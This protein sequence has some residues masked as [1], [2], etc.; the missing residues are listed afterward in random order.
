MRFFPGDIFPP[1]STCFPHFHYVM[2]FPCSDLLLFVC[3]SYMYALVIFLSYSAAI[4]QAVSMALS[5][6]LRSVHGRL[7]RSP[8]E[9]G[10][11]RRPISDGWE[12]TWVSSRTGTRSVLVLHDAS[13]AWW[14]LVSIC[15]KQECISR[16]CPVEEERVT[17][18]CAHSIGRVLDL[19]QN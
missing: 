9:M 10:G 3:E 7:M 6:S 1:Y 14:S 4:S 11:R 13:M 16:L 19:C 15:K 5:C 12:P 17:S 18:I 2:H 8:Q